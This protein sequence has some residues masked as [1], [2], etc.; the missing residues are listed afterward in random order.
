MHEDFLNLVFGIC[1][2]QALGKFDSTKGGHMYF[3]QL[4]FATEFPSGCMTLFPSA[5]LTHGNVPIQPKETRSSLVHYSSAGLFR[6]TDYGF[7]TKTF[8]KAG[9]TDS[10]WKQWEKED[11]KKN[12]EQLATP[13]N[14]F[15]TMASL[16]TDHD[17]VW[18]PEAR[19]TK[20]RK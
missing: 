14:M 12:G 5:A 4:K 9:M 6:Y 10:R 13:L 17:K 15:S 3:P 20:K 19:P 7:R 8:I 1:T 2:I 11:N 16:F 18:P